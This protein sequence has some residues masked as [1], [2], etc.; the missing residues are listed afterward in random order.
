MRKHKGNFTIALLTI[1]LMTLGLVIIYPTGSQKASSMNVIY[2]VNQD[3]NGFFWKQL[4]SVGLAVVAF[5]VMATR[6]SYKSLQKYAKW[7]L[8]AGLVACI[9]LAIL[10]RWHVYVLA[11]CELGACRWYKLGPVGFQPAELLKVGLVLYLAKMMTER[12]KEGRLG[13]KEFW[14]TFG[15]LMVIALWLVVKEQKD[16][17]TG[18][19]IVAIMMAML[20]VSGVKMREIVLMLAILMVAGV[21]AVIGSPHR[22]ER[23]TTY[24][25]AAGADTYHIDNA[26]MAI[27]TGGLWGV[28][29][30]NSV[31]ATGYLPESMNDSVF[32]IMGETFGFVG[33]VLILAAFFYLARNLLKTAEAMENLEKRLV[34]VGVFAWLGSQVVINSASMMGMIPMT[35]ITLPLLSFGGTSMILMAGMLGLAF[36]LSCWTSREGQNIA[37]GEGGLLATKREGRGGVPET[38]RRFLIDGGMRREKGRRENGGTG[39]LMRFRRELRR[40]KK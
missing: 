9:V 16:L 3:T 28:G 10:A 2:G 29:I 8:L 37:D 34:L 13:K 24:S 35:G 7:I 25:G 36:Q 39:E 4:I 30:G 22:M 38:A 33:M 14:K 26:K 11:R 12:K 32:A 5:V 18:V 31:Q 19:S 40:R 20:F 15:W 17:G 21:G 1:L 27:G 6:V 23:L